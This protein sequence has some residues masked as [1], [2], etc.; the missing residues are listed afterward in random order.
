MNQV[1]TYF[2]NFDLIDEKKI[3]ILF[4]PG[5]GMDHRFI[6]A[7]N[8][9]HAEFNK[10]LAID[11]PGH[12][13]SQGISSNNISSY[14]QFLVSAL[15]DL[16]L[17]N[18][19]LCGHSMGGLIALDMVVSNNFLPKSI[20][21]LNSIYPTVVSDVLLAKAQASNALAAD[22]IIKYGLHRKL[23]GMKNIFPE[24]NNAVMFKDLKACN[25]YKLDM[26][27]LKNLNLPLSIILGSKDKLVNLKEVKNFT[28]Q[29]PST[30]YEMEDVGHFPFFEN[31]AELS[32]LIASLV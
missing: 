26:D 8:L 23:L 30:I 5:A 3:S 27:S 19:Y 15:E 9:P 24:K 32:N 11:L 14:S 31:P 20:I 2:H 10:P 25:D 29:I 28:S 4:I 12:G 21:L 22:F 18:L 13:N 17:E 1:S 16:N 7:L 6:R